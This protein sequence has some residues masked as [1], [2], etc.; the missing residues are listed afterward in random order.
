[1]TR[2]IRDPRAY[3]ARCARDKIITS[4]CGPYGSL[5]ARNSLFLTYQIENCELTKTVG[6]AY[7]PVIILFNIAHK[8]SY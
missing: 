8:D 5:F 4:L 3:C 2:A 1:M 6:K 7:V